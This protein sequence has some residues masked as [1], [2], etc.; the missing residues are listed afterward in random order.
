MTR[1]LSIRL[2]LPGHPLDLVP[3]DPREARAGL[4]F[5]A[6]LDHFGAGALERLPAPGHITASAYLVTPDLAWVLVM[7]HAKLDRWLQPGGH[8]DGM[9]DLVAVARK[10]AAEETGVVPGA[11]DSPAPLLVDV[12]R[13]P[14]RGNVP[15]HLHYDAGFLFRIPADARLQANAESRGLAWVRTARIA[16]RDGRD[17]LTRAAR[18]VRARAGGAS[19]GRGLPPAGP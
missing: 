4:A 19:R 6:L 8:A 16:G 3:G 5:A 18:R 1:G 12:H 13:I 11:P 7:H 14:A 17:A 15:A 9:A 10:E 2:P